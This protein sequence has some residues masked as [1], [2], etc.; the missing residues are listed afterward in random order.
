MKANT[1]LKGG[2]IAKKD[3]INTYP[4]TRQRHLQKGEL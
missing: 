4:K 3:E 1:S 2:K